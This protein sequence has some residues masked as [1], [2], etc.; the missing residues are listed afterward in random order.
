M[1]IGVRLD[2]VVGVGGDLAFPP[3]S[4]YAKVPKSI[5]YAG[6]SREIGIDGI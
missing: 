2:A 6:D 5:L 3:F 1:L 4:P